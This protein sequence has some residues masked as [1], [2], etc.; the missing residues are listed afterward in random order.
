M[1]LRRPNIALVLTLIT[2]IGHAQHA[3][4]PGFWQ[5][6]TI[7]ITDDAG[8]PL[9]DATAAMV[10]YGS[11]FDCF[12]F[13]PTDASGQITFDATATVGNS[14]QGFVPGNY[15]VLA[16]A[17]DKAPALTTLELPT[18]APVRV[19]LKTGTPIELQLTPYGETTLPATLRPVIVPHTFNRAAMLPQAAPPTWITPVGYGRFR[20]HLDETTSAPWT[21]HINQPGYLR[22]YHRALD[23]PDLLSSKKLNI[24]LPQPGRF[25]LRLT[26]PPKWQHLAPD[27]LFR[28]SVSYLLPTDDKE[29]RYYEMAANQTSITVHSRRT[30]SFFHLAPGQY[31]ASI[32]GASATRPDSPEDK[33]N[34]GEGT[35]IRPDGETTLPLTYTRFEQEKLRGDYTAHVTVT[36]GEGTPA[37]AE[38]VKLIY[39]D[40]N[41][42][43]VTVTSGTL[44]DHGTT[45]IANL[46]G[47]TYPPTTF[48]LMRDEAPGRVDE[49]FI[50][51]IELTEKET[52][53][54]FNL[55]PGAGDPAP[56]ITLTD[57]FTSDTV[58][59]SD[60]RGK[61]VIL[62]F[63]AT[64]CGPCQQPMAHNQELAVRFA[65][66]WKDRVAIIA[67]SIDDDPQTVIDHVRQKGWT[68][69]THLWCGPGSF[70]SEPPAA[71][72]VHG[73]PTILVIDQTGTIAFRGYP[74]GE[75]LE[76]T[77][78]E[79][80][81]KP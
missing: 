40:R 42:G 36:R 8:A 24:A 79:L 64:W 4:L 31:Y 50:G 73:I 56:D 49:P 3:P 67:A 75:T 23:H 44:D 46:A 28:Y 13:L 14:E 35:S 62:D 65:E 30:E 25:N 63:W 68:D 18:S 37:A 60:Y 57:I 69:V 48:R 26:I 78:N 55:A 20:F 6:T 38:P 12:T 22:A 76:N 7:T 80:L 71:Y 58:R 15:R 59:L 29:G 19:A 9:P 51:R 21:L 74:A 70:E 16:L 72:S 2:G 77:V 61:V 47:N 66:E 34:A 33:F 43:E 17:P 39:Y 41:A 32:T 45:T 10:R 54:T 11:P 5:S 52:S 27:L 53:L 1:R 81:E